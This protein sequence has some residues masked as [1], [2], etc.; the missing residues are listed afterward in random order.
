MS[1]SE[2]TQI[3]IG[4]NVPAD[5]ADLRRKNLKISVYRQEVLINFEASADKERMAISVFTLWLQP[6]EQKQL[7]AI[8]LQ[9]LK[10]LNAKASKE[11][12]KVNHRAEAPVKK[13]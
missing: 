8:R 7:K 13:G 12:E 10:G 1:N 5:I 4:N 3:L 2:S 11:T 6:G 9:P